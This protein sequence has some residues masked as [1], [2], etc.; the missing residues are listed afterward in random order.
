MLKRWVI[1]IAIL[2]VTVAVPVKPRNIGDMLPVRV[3]GIYKE[4][5][6]FRIDTDTGNQGYGATVGE[7]LQNL[8]DSA[9][10][11]VY[12]DTVEYLAITK[13]TEAAVDMLRQRLKSG[14]EVCMVQGPLDLAKLG[15]YLDAHGTLPK[16]R[17]WKTSTEVPLMGVFEDSKTFLKK[18]EKR[19]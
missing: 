6:R 3:V 4:G 1:Y 16:L 14:T 10:G 7:A 18:V 15:E 12:L 5:N 17:N 2:V 8:E 9:V 19:Y 13:E 11:V